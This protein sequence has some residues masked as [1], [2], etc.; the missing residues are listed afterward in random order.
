[1]LLV[2]DDSSRLSA[3]NLS[4]GCYRKSLLSL[5]EAVGRFDVVPVFPA[6]WVDGSLLQALLAFRQ[7]LVFADSHDV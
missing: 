5:C 4:A 6:E 7:A 1:M 2:A 3:L